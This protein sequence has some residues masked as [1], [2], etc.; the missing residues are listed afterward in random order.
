MSPSVTY[1][2]ADA[3]KRYEWSQLASSKY[4]ALFEGVAED[5][6]E[7]RAEIIEPYIRYMEE[8]QR[9]TVDTTPDGMRKLISMLNDTV[10][11]PIT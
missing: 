1:S 6:F 3:E 4:D 7:K 2:F 8:A 9:E 11:I 5:D 10:C